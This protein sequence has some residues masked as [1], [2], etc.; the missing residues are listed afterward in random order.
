M[1]KGYGLKITDIGS[2]AVNNKQAHFARNTL[3]RC[4]RVER[5][6][7]ISRQLTSGF[8]PTRARNPKTISAFPP[9]HRAPLDTA[10]PRMFSTT[11]GAII[12]QRSPSHCTPKN[13]KKGT[14]APT[15][16]NGATKKL[17]TTYDCKPTSHPSKKTAPCPCTPASP[18]R[19]LGG[20]D[21]ATS[22]IKFASA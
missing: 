5:G 7:W 20:S 14:C 2:A 6:F 18:S 4:L 1:A 16:S 9:Y 21:N 15:C 11:V 22:T 19:A 12:H 3:R 8:L 10:K 13:T 17:S